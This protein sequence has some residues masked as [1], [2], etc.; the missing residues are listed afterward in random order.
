MT[1]PLDAPC[2]PT[3][4]KLAA[5]GTAICYSTHY[6]PEV[7]ALDAQVV[8]LKNGAVATTGAV[9][10]L[11]DRYGRTVI[12][13]RIGEGDGEDGRTI[14]LEADGPDALPGVLQGLGPDLNRLVGLE[15]RLPSLDEVFDRVV[16]AD[17]DGVRADV[18]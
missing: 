9:A 16:E 2:S 1:R 10:D 7:E 5:E 13:L 6:L 15:I 18:P 14:S 11:L 17:T 3:C 8:L 4:G 12:D